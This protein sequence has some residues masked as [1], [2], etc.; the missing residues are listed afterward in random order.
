MSLGNVS[1][2]IFG[3]WSSE[4]GE[5]GRPFSWVDESSED[6]LDYFAALDLAAAESLL[7]STPR[8]ALV[9]SI[10]ASPGESQRRKKMGV[11]KQSV[12]ESL[13]CVRRHCRMGMKRS[14]LRSG[15]RL[16]Q[17]TRRKL[18]AATSGSCIRKGYL[19]D[20]FE[21]ELRLMLF[22]FR[23]VGLILK[24]DPM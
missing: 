15:P 11:S 4:G 13:R 3:S 7:W 8:E 20:L 17:G 10:G 22:N 16:D 5:L 19:R 6:E 9:A 18:L 23:E 12:S 24:E 1:R 2:Q 14:R 21:E